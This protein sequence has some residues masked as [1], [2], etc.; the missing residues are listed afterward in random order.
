MGI[1]TTI[2]LTL[3][4]GK[5]PRHWWAE[6]MLVSLGY[7]YIPGC[8]MS[9]VPALALYAIMYKDAWVAWIALDCAFVTWVTTLLLFPA[10]LGVAVVREDRLALR[11]YRM[12]KQRL[13][14]LGVEERFF[15]PSL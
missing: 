3:L 2:R 7:L 8:L 13:L 14:E 11:M 4:R 1:I 6:P 15:P 12:W 10:V 9:F 5:T